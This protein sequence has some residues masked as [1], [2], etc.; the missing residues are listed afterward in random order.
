MVN[1][2]VV[3]TNLLSILD[4]KKMSKNSLSHVIAL[5]V[6]L[7][8]T[9]FFHAKLSLPFIMQAESEFKMYI[10]YSVPLL[11]SL[12][13]LL[14]TLAVLNWICVSFWEDGKYI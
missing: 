4:I 11:W 14:L 10:Q 12:L 8:I 7:S 2:F 5:L 13:L 6:W 9:W 1:Q 3:I